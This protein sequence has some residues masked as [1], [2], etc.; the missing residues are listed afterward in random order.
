M[1]FYKR[2]H[3]FDITD[4]EFLGNPMIYTQPYLYQNAFVVP[5]GYSGYGPLPKVFTFFLAHPILKAFFPPTILCI[6][7]HSIAT[8][9]PYHR[10]N[11]SPTPFGGCME[12]GML[13]N[14]SSVRS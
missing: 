10:R 8:P 13:A 14:L 11:K 12:L 4:I 3:I 7:N 5:T 2:R 1:G 6:H 9:I